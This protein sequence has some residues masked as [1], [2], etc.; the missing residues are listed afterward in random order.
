M[1]RHACAQG[2]DKD[3]LFILTAR[4]KFAVLSF[5]KAA[6]IIVTEAHGDARVRAV[7]SP[8]HARARMCAC[9]GSGDF[10]S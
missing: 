10:V 9:V 4:Q 6:G 8:A 5:D 7:I 2:Y 3:L 1:A